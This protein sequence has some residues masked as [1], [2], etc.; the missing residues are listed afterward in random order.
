MRLGDG[1]WLGPV[2]IGRD[3]GRDERQGE[4]DAWA[5]VGNDPTVYRI[6]PQILGK[7]PATVDELAV[8]TK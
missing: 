2:L 6:S 7:L 3:E 4:G 5:R 8:A 1:G